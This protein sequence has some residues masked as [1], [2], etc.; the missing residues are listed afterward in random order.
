MQVADELGSLVDPE[1]AVDVWMW[2]LTVYVDM[3][4]CS[5]TA[6]AVYP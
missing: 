1:P 2:L 3:T 4:S 6:D 5:A